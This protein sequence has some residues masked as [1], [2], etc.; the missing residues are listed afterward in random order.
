MP[1]GTSAKARNWTFTFNLWTE[2]EL[3]TGAWQ[4]GWKWMPPKVTPHTELKYVRMSME[5]GEEG[6]FHWQGFCA[7]KEST[8]LR[9]MKRALGVNT[10]HLEPMMAS[11]SQ[12]ID[13]V[14]KDPIMEYEDGK[15]PL[16]NQGRRTDMEFAKRILDMGGSLKDVAEEC[17]G[18]FIR[19]HKGFDRY[20]S[21]Q[22]RPRES[23]R[24]VSVEVHWGVS[25]AGKTHNIWTQYPDLYC[26]HLGEKDTGWWDGYIGQDVILFD[27]FVGQI[28]INRMKV[29]TDK[30]PCTV[31]YKGLDNCPARYVLRFQ[32]LLNTDGRRCSSRRTTTRTIGG[33]RRRLSKTCKR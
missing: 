13:Y 26:V 32:P 3:L 6:R 17:F 20:L 31:S 30:W 29:L 2:A 15:P 24:S 5:L 21:I 7:F 22:T 27:D 14:T 23:F 19:Y 33:R 11:L 8:R 9:A 12:N 25:G 10:I 16:E 28:P 18:Q 4:A 1:K